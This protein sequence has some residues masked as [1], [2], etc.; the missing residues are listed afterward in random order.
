M[1]TRGKIEDV[2][3]KGRTGHGW[4]HGRCCSCA[5]GK[6]NNAEKEGTSARI[7]HIVFSWILP[8]IEGRVQ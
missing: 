2:A 7:G 1:P 8:V 3:E 4:W 6:E 5:Y